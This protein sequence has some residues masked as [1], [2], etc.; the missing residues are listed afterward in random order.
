MNVE[1]EDRYT[2]KGCFKY[3]R[4]AELPNWCINV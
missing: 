1:C 2:A 3:F 4:R